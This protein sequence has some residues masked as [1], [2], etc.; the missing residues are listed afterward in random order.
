MSNP[1][2]VLYH[3]FRASGEVSVVIVFESDELCHPARF[4]RLLQNRDRSIFFLHRIHVVTM[5]VY[6]N[7]M[8]GNTENVVYHTLRASIEI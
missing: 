6:V 1:E 3:T 2:N 5:L 8:C 7:D 4:V